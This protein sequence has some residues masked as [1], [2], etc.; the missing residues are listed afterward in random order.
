MNKDSNE[1]E[2]KEVCLVSFQNS[3]HTL[4]QWS[5]HP[6]SLH[7]HTQEEE[8]RP[9]EIYF[10]TLFGCVR[11]SFK[12]LLTIVPAGQHFICLTLTLA[13]CRYKLPYSTVTVPLGCP[14]ISQLLHCA[15]LQFMNSSVDDL[16]M[17]KMV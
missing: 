9:P 13:I 5:A 17:N 3:P 11:I 2:G 16:S 4:T 7:I 10:M 6:A 1:L 8:T 15:T 14:W 12:L